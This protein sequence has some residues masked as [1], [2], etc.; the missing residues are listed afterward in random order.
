MKFLKDKIEKNMKFEKLKL[1]YYDL[2]LFKNSVGRKL[3]ENKKSL[4]CLEFE[5]V[6]V[7]K[8]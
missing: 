6:H 7:F 1:F 8:K 5:N 2:N 3:C 4:F